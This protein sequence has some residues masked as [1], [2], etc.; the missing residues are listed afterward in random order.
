MV[1][2]Q[3]TWLTVEEV[4]EELNFSTQTIRNWIRASKG[5]RLEA[6]RFGLRQFRINRNAVDDFIRAS[7]PDQPQV[8][9]EPEQRQS[10]S[11]EVRRY[12]ADVHGL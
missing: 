12:L 3:R 8:S 5:P 2:A 11:Q 9:A 10:S 4:A 1:A 6:T 7:N